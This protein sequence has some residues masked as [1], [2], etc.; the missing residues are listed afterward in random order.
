MYM[1]EREKEYH[2]HLIFKIVALGMY[3]LAHS[4]CYIDRYATFASIH[5]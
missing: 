4:Q 3:K 2:E 1:L 5:P